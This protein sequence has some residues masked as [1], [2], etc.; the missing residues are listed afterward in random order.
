MQ[1]AKIYLKLMQHSRYYCI[2]NLK[3]YTKIGIWNICILTST[4]MLDVQQCPLL[5]NTLL[6]F[7]KKKHTLLFLQTTMLSK[8][9]WVEPPWKAFPSSYG[10]R[11]WGT[12]TLGDTHNHM[13]RLQQCKIL[14]VYWTLCSSVFTWNFKGRQTK[15]SVWFPWRVGSYRLESGICVKQESKFLEVQYSLLILYCPSTQQKYIWLALT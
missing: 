9:R 13:S 6:Y 8:Y 7:R 14:H 12:R 15:I 1:V 11:K 5:N 4:W 3:K 2:R 10:Y